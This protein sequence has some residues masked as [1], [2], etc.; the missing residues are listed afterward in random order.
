[1]TLGFG[2]KMS[3]SDGS[4][5]GGSTAFPARL[6]RWLCSERHLPHWVRVLMGPSIKVLCSVLRVGAGPQLDS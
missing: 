4:W 3:V 2:N 1:M 5:D 6:P